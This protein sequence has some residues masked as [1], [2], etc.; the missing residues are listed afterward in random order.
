MANEYVDFDR[1]TAGQKVRVLTDSHV[2]SGFPRSCEAFIRSIDRSDQILPWSIGN[3]RVPEDRVW[4]RDGEVE[5]W[6]LPPKFSSIEEAD[7]WLE[8]NAHH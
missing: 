7:A 4:V 5:P 1:F 2:D 6:P 8:A 3:G